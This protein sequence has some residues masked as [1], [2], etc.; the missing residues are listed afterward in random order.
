MTTLIRVLDWMKWKYLLAM[1][2]LVWMVFLLM[3]AN[4]IFYS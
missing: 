1:V 2:A 4:V 3:L